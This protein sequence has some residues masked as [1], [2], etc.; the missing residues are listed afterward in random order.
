M[1]H[2]LAS[3]RLGLVLIVGLMALIGVSAAGV[4]GS[5]G[6]SPSSEFASQLSIYVVDST[7]DGSDADLN[8]PSCDDGTGAWSLRA[9]I[10]QAN[11]HT[12]SDTINFNIPGVGP[13]TIQPNSALPVITEAVVIDGYT[14]LGANPNTNPPG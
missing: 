2:W 4:L 11:F 6:G 12:G 7:G 10:Q 1:V 5:G 9:A 14:Q 13:H 8:I 3:N